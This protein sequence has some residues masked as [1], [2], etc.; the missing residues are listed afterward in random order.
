MVA[1]CLRLLID[2]NLPLNEGLLSP[3]RITIPKGSLLSPVFPK[4]LEKCPGVAGGNVE[5]SQKLVELILLAFQEV[6]GSSR[7]DE[8]CYIWERI[9]QSL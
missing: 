5:I 8:Q 7:H 4:N 1:Y 2:V 3:V 9:V 6:A